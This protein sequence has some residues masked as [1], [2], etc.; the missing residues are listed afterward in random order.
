MATR[1][2]RSRKAVPEAVPEAVPQLGYVEPLEMPPIDTTKPVKSLL[3][4]LLQAWNWAV[5]S[6]SGNKKFPELNHW[7]Q[8]SLLRRLREAIATAF[9]QVVEQ[10]AAGPMRCARIKI[11]K[12]TFSPDAG[13]TA[14]IT[15]DKN[16]K[17]AQHMLANHAGGTLLLV[18][19]HDASFNAQLDE[20]QSTDDQNEIEFDEWDK[21]Q[22]AEEAADDVPA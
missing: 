9:D 2:S 18:F 12:V 20:V 13:V 17:I 15:M 14:S 19:T 10:A 4:G 8:D 21:Q 22:E 7:S 16:N 3:L 6:Y 11:G 1:K 5:D